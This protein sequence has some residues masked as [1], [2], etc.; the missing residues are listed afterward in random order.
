MGDTDTEDVKIDMEEIESSSKEIPQQSIDP[1]GE[2]LEEDSNDED[3]KQENQDQER[4]QLSV[5]PSN[6]KVGD[7]VNCVYG[8]GNIK[9]IREDG[10]LMDFLS[11]IDAHHTHS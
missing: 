4:Q 5:Q 9:E 11:N 7:V 10:K 3:A 2:S 8:R 1:I 6:Y